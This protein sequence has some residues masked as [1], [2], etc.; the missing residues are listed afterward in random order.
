METEKPVIITPQKMKEDA[1]PFVNEECG[2]TMWDDVL[3]EQ[4]KKTPLKDPAEKT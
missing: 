3:E 2:D 1:L 4:D